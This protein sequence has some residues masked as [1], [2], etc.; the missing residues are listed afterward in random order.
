MKNILFRI[1]IVLSI[2]SGFLSY[3]SGIV[4]TERLKNASVKE[5]RATTSTFSS[6]DEIPVYLRDVS[7]QDQSVETPDDSRLSGK[8]EVI[9]YPVDGKSDNVDTSFFT[10]HNIEY[11]KSESYLIAYIPV[12]LIPELEEVSVALCGYKRPCKT[13]GNCQRRQRCDQCN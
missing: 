9:F 4:I 6:E 2:L 11:I 13:Y 5:Q 8:I 1:V 12:E 3:A 10:R 7:G